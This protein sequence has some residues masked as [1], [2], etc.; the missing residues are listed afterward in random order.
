MPEV[1]SQ[2]QI[3]ALISSMASGGGDKEEPK[4][5]E[6][7]YKKYDFYSPKK[8]TKDK[9]K[10]LFGIY[11]NYARLCSSRINSIVRVSSTVEVAA[12]EEERY[13]EFSNALSDNDIITLINARMP[14]DTMHGPIVLHTTGPLIISMVDRMI[15]GVGDDAEDISS[16][17]VYTDIEIS[18]Y[19]NIVK[20]LI[21]IMADGWVNYLDLKF[22]FEKVETNPGM[23]QRIGRDETVVIVVLDVEVGGVKG[24]I[25]ICLPGNF[26]T[27]VFKALESKDERNEH[28]DS[29]SEEIFDNIKSTKM[30]IRAEL[31]SSLLSLKDIYSLQVGDVINL[32]KSKDSDVLLYVEGEPWF[33][34]ELG[35][36]NKNM[37]VK[38]NDICE[39]I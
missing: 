2:S 22:E 24:R 20:Y 6:K 5:E 33:R 13:Y 1:L 39:K 8:F 12:V 19:H 21:A 7:S 28:E 37:A 29:S 18:L 15:G 36:S 32:N 26:L 27:S 34:G 10:M 3:D 25:N 11:E 4:K 16:S 17:Y 35:K 38:I 30:E 9:L 14:D 23:M 31:G